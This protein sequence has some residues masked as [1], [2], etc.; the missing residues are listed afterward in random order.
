MP[1]A[2][3]TPSL[4]PTDPRLLAYLNLKLRE[5][6]QPGV[7]LQGENDL[8][9]FAGHFLALGREKIGRAHV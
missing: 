3:Q 6:G 9:S 5:I 2:D 4:D 7:A 1:P 8:A